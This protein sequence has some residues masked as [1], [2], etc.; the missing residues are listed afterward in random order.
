MG[1]KS[2][3]KTADIQASL[4]WQDHISAPDLLYILQRERASVSLGCCEGSNVDKKYQCIVCDGS[5]SKP[6]GLQR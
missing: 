3:V 6:L 2:E 5:R 1:S 4:K